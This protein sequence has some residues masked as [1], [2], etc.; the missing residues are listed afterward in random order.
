MVY[1]E[2]NNVLSSISSSIHTAESDY[3]S[4]S[5]ILTF[6]PG[7]PPGSTQCFSVSI[8][9]DTVLE[10]DGSFSLQLLAPNPAVVSTTLEKDRTTVTITDDDGTLL[11]LFYT[12]YKEK[13]SL[14]IFNSYSF[15]LF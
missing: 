5:A 2:L 14:Q 11:L 12:I 6:F 10:S 9:D 13:L 8:I 4:V 3:S 7:S 1:S 15:L